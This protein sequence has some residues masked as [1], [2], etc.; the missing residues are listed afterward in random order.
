MFGIYP[1]LALLSVNLGEVKAYVVYR[2]VLVSFFLVVVLFLG[3]WLFFH[4]TQ[5]AAFLTG[6]LLMLF[7][8]YGHVFNLLG[9]NE[10]GIKPSQYMPFLFVLFVAS[11][12]V[13]VNRTDLN[14]KA[15]IPSFNL[16][17]LGLVVVTICQIS[18]KD[19]AIDGNPLGAKHAPVD[20]NLVLP[21]N[22]QDIYYFI[23]DSYGRADLLKQAYD[24]DNSEFI[25]DLRNRGF[26]VADCSM[27]NYVRTE[28]SLGSSLNM[29][30]LQDLDETF[31]PE[32]TSRRL[33]WNSLKHSAVRFNLERLGYQTIAF[34]TGFAWNELTDADQ[35]LSPPPFASGLNEFEAMFIQTTFARHLSDIGW[36]DPD[37]IMG[38]K[39]RDRFN[40]IFNSMDDLVKIEDPIF[41]VIHVISPH[42]PFVFDANGNPTYP[43]DF[44][45][46]N[47]Q[48]PPDLYAKGYQNQTTYLNKKMLEAIDTLIRGSNTQPI[49]IIQ[50]DHGPWLQPK[51]KRLWILNAY[52]LPGHL[53]ALYPSI[54]PVNSFRLVFNLYF[55]GNYDMLK[56]VS[57]F[58]PV[59]NLYDF[60][61]MPNLCGH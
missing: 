8:S 43:P 17:S 11:S 60:T 5:K 30:Y 15:L 29:T 42:P 12:V 41:A 4:Q 27:A 35:F 51:D 58:S 47:R 52:Y 13:W 22:P 25:Y 9:E 16:I 20:D 53:D 44:W 56:D 28:I 38:R 57:Y 3:S 54:S 37:A 34:A 36:L 7:F 49:I 46:E 26:Y 23:L 21:A 2:P 31:R 19:N 55:G 59:P 6:G 32:S 10:T 45:N 48:Y 40:Y 50:G 1:A 39:Y 33:L 61:E 24:Y 14:F 18:L